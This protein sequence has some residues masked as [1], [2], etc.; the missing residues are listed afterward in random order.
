MTHGRSLESKVA[1]SR[2]G[3]KGQ[4]K[5][6]TVDK[7]R[8]FYIQYMYNN[9]ENSKNGQGQTGPLLEE[10]DSDGN[11]ELGAVR[12]LEDCAPG[13]LH[14]IGLGGWSLGEDPVF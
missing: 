4:P 10:L 6:R 5:G 9:V 13:V 2:G 3:A 12:R 7:E 11:D 14:Q 8:K 1:K